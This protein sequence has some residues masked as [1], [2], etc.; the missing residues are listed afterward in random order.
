MSTSRPTRH[1][2]RT[3][4]NILSVILRSAARGACRRRAHR[5][6]YAYPL[7][8]IGT[9]AKPKYPTVSDIVAVNEHEF[10]VDERDGKG[11]GDDSAASFKRLYHIDLAGAAEVG[12]LSGATSL[13]A[14]AVTKTL[15]LDVVTILNAAGIA[16]T[17][18]P[19]KLEGVAFGQD[20]TIAGVTEHTLFIANDN[21]FL[22]SLTDT[23]HP[24]GVDNPNKWFVFAF[25]GSDL[26]GY[27]PQQIEPLEP[28]WDDDEHK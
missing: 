18:I 15:F 16:S 2:K 6:E 3:N 22:A 9:A 26:P 17:E 10:L 11:L 8:N 19:A 23:H 28:F 14:K 4:R 5:N 12:E 24:N 21:D 1:E 25:A 20:V 27:V 13:A 7:T